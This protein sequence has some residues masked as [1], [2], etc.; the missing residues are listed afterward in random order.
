MGIFNFFKKEKTNKK[1][2]ENIKR[3]C[4]N[5]DE[6]EDVGIVT[7]YKGKP[8]TG[9]A[10]ELHEFGKVEYEMENGLKHGKS[11]EYDLANN[12]IDVLYYKND[13]YDHSGEKISRTIDYKFRKIERKDHQLVKINWLKNTGPIYKDTGDIVLEFRTLYSNGNEEV[14]ILFE[15][16]LGLDWAINTLISLN[17]GST[18]VNLDDI[19]PLGLVCKEKNFDINSQFTRSGPIINLIKNN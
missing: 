13:Q 1:E 12:I 18:R 15:T 8:F 19:S 3:L 7:H 16:K 9:I 2:T 5:W 6:M 11:I 17:G 4:V 10:I 14:F